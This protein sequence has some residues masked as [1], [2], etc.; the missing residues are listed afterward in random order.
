MMTHMAL[1]QASIF[2]ERLSF[3]ILNTLN[4]LS[5]HFFNY[6]SILFNFKCNTGYDYD[7]DLC[8]NPDEAHV[9]TGSCSHDEFFDPLVVKKLQSIEKYG[10]TKTRFCCTEHEYVFKDYCEV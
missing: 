6:F 9:T 1:I 4:N 7:Y 10:S 2:F 5:I 3:F 8:S